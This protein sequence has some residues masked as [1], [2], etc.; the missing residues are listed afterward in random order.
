M[1]LALRIAVLLCVAFATPG[2]GAQP[3]DFP[4]APVRWIDVHMHLVPPRPGGSE[5]RE[6]LDAA[7]TEM[8]RVGIAYALVLPPPQVEGLPVIWDTLTGRSD[9]R[10]ARQRFG[11]LAGGGTLN[12]MLHRY[13]NPA[14]V[15]DEVRAR[16]ARTAREIVE[17][18][19]RGFGEIASLHLSAMPGHPFEFVPADHPLLLLLADIAAEH[20]LPID[21]HMDASDGPTRLP[22]TYSRAQNPAELPDTVAPLK[23][24]L[25]H[26]PRAA[27]V[28][29]H[30]GSDPVGGQGPALLSQLM[31]LHENLFVSLRLLPDRP[32]G[33]RG[34]GANLGHEHGNRVFTV[35]G[36][37]P[38]WLTLLRRHPDRFVIGTDV[39][40]VSPNMRGGG[41]AVTFAAANMAHF[42]A[43]NRFLSLLPGD[44]MQRIATD[45]ARRIYRLP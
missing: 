11:F 35:A 8:D 24:L 14:L 3:R 39:F 36:I 32:P 38:E 42:A 23:R 34:G 9:L 13:G 45:N 12:V 37:V 4:Q 31:D 6:V 15:T 33:Q 25:A 5:L 41:P 30:G 22:E 2:A 40:I 19:A 7:R 16:F 20:G 29:A 10:D 26:N 21:L 17:S 43:S 1:R 44:L 27:I 18:G 28:W